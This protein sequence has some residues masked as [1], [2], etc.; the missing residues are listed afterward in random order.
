LSTHRHA[1]A[2]LHLASRRQVEEAAAESAAAAAAAKA[3]A[4]ERE[5]QLSKK[6]L[7]KKELEELDAVFAELGI[8]VEGGDK[9]GEGAAGGKKKKKKDKAKG[10]EQQQAEANGGAAAASSSK[11]APAP[12]PAETA[13]E[14]EAREAAEVLDPA[15][16]RLMGHKGATGADDFCCGSATWAC[17]SYLVL[18]LSIRRWWCVCLP[19]AALRWRPPKARLSCRSPPSTPPLPQVKAR[20]AAKKK[21]E[22][23]NKKKPT[24][25]AALAAAEARARAKKA[26]SKKDTSHYNQ[27]P[28]R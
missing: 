3:A 20:L 17:S 5:R 9:E 16:V 7:K 27:A 25:A 1:P 2:R 6:E 10:G 19:A 14:A 26:A 23:A 15:V 8:N 18:P 12:E 22:A 4:A 21:A 11:P 24:A 28:T 13:A